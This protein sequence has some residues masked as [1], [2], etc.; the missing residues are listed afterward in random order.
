MPCGGGSINFE[1]LHNGTQTVGEGKDVDSLE[2]VKIDSPRRG[3]YSI[4]IRQNIKE[5]DQASLSHSDFQRQQARMV[6]VYIGK[7]NKRFPLP[8]L[9]G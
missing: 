6:E 8:K 9:P 7:K 1:V 2:I 3:R 5:T 4:K